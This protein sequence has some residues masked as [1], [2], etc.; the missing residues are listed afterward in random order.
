MKNSILICLVLATT[1]FSSF[2]QERLP[3]SIFDISDKFKDEITIGELQKI[4][5][6][7]TNR[8]DLEVSGFILSYI[9][10][11]QVVENKSTS[12]YFTEK[13]I[14]LNKDFPIGSKVYIESITLHS[15]SD[16]EKSIK[17]EPI[18]LLVKKDKRVKTRF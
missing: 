5:S 3:K 12:R 9:L 10:D 18:I 6:L 11:G 2:S 15:K 14:T 1:A 8:K 17:A 4:K 16:P 7:E 13:M